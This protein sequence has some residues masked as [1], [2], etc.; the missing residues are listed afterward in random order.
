MNKTMICTIDDND[1]MEMVSES[2]GERQLDITEFVQRWRT[3]KS[4]ASAPPTHD[5]LK[6][7]VETARQAMTRTHPP[8]RADFLAEV[9]RCLIPRG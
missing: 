3:R 2:T 5:Q 7:V 6:A 9:R 4:I 1:L 8:S